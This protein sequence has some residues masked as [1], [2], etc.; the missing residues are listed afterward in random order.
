MTQN[1]AAQLF[2]AVKQD[3]AL[4]ERLKAAENPETFIQVAQERGYNFTIEELE[5]E[6]SKLSS[7]ELAAIVN[8][9]VR[10][11]LHIYPR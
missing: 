8:P 5:T 2:K 6:L 1:H 4:K 7:E 10:P 9:G 11:R 3:Q